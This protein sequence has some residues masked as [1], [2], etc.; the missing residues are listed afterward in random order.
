[1][2]KFLEDNMMPIVVMFVTLGF[3]CVLAFVVVR[4]NNKDIRRE[5]CQVEQFKYCMEKNSISSDACSFAA[6]RI[7]GLT[8]Q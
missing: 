4:T 1:M 6:E 3:F 2:L 7:C 5:A 8:R